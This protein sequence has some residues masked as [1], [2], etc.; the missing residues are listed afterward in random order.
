MHSHLFS[1]ET[2]EP[3]QLLPRPGSIL[4]AG[5]TVS[6]PP[7][8]SPFLPSVTT[9]NALKGNPGTPGAQRFPAAGFHLLEGKV[10]GTRLP[11]SQHCLQLYCCPDARAL[12]PSC[13]FSSFP[14]ALAEWAWS[15]PAHPSRHFSLPL[16]S[17]SS[18]SPSSFL[19]FFNSLS[20]ELEKDQVTT[21]CLLTFWRLWVLPGRKENR[22]L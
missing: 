21:L 11:P 9:A 10:A 22:R 13:P 5:H 8:L 19:V 17:S 3:V 12:V 2:N 1:S 4:A 18:S 7:Y 20:P 15:P 6:Q 14:L 16:T